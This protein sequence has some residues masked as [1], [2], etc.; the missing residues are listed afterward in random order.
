MG[1]GTTFTVN[2]TF[3][4]QYTDGREYGWDINSG[5]LELKGDVD[6]LDATRQTIGS[7]QLIATGTNDQII[8]SAGG[9]LPNLTL[10]KPSGTLSVTGN[11]SM[12][13]LTLTSG[14]ISNTYGNITLQNF[15]RDVTATFIH[16]TGIIYFNTPHWGSTT[17]NVGTQELYN[18]Y[19]R[20]SRG[21]RIN[22]S[23]GKLIIL[24]D[25]TIAPTDIYGNDSTQINAGDLILYGNLLIGY[26]ARGGTA[27]L[28][29]VGTNNQTYACEYGGYRLR[30]DWTIGKSGGKLLLNTNLVLTGTGQELFWTNGTLDLGGYDLTI[31]NDFDIEHTLRLKGHE[32]ITANQTT[33]STSSGT[34][35]YYDA[36]V[37]TIVN[38]LSEEYHNLTFGADK[39]HLF[40]V[41]NTVTVCGA[42]SSEATTTNRAILRSVTNDVSWVLNL[43]GTSSLSN[44]VD[45]KD[46]DASSGNTVLAVDSLDS[47]SNTNWMFILFKPRLFTS[48]TL[49]G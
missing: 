15:T 11:V 1:V 27:T 14:I 13:T 20:G 45:V 12:T 18:A 7:A 46:S 5:T 44:T 37:T 47:G 48:C 41:G 22:L 39:T 8:T 6:I 42:L 30:G 19:F 28:S 35:V 21:G 38:T 31:L 17:I 26:R 2:G 24:N 10:D 23:N 40:S 16:K 9:G 32:T 25:L 3:T 29:F 34:V 33:V 36:S 4:I 49:S 43:Q